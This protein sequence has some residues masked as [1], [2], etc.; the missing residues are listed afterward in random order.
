MLKIATSTLAVSTNTIVH[1]YTPTLCLNLSCDIF[2]SVTVRV[3]AENASS[4]SVHAGVS[5]LAGE[6]RRK[7]AYT[8]R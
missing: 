4:P 6:E 2:G 3:Y 8:I 5:L 7:E 1:R